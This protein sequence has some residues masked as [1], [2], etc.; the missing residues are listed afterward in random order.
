M[1]LDEGRLERS[2]RHAL[3]FCSAVPD[4][5]P[6]A[7][8][9]VLHGYAEHAGRYR[10]FMQ[11]LAERGIGAFAIDMHGHGRSDGDRGFCERFEDY[12]DDVDE[13]AR[14]MATKA[15]GVPAFLFGHSTGGLIAAAH[16]I[17]RPGAFRGLL[18]SAPYLGLRLGVPFHKLAAAKVAQRIYPKL[19]VPSGL[20]GRDLTHDEALAKAY[21]E[22]PLIFKKATAGWFCET[23]KAQAWV[24]ARAA[25]VKLP[26]YVVFG[27]EDRVAKLETGQAFH[28]A[29]SSTDKTWDRRDGLFHEVLNE[30]SRNDI[31]LTM[32]EWIEART[33]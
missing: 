32:A 1:R 31:M 3:Y 7:A 24:T 14:L 6:K 22:D 18:L 33:K 11:F 4:G 10:P 8:V 2:G 12:L 9:G 23:Q 13:L 29:A 27:T 20:S 26:L 21:D 16:V 30:P 19:G 25:E 28:N 5:P 15:P 17:A